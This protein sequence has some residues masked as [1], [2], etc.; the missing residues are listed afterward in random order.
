M[1][2]SDLTSGKTMLILSEQAGLAEVLMAFETGSSHLP[3]MSNS[4]K[5]IGFLTEADIRFARD[6]EVAGKWLTGAAPDIE[7]DATVSEA[8]EKMIAE[9][10]SALLLRGINGEVTGMITNQDL[11]RFLIQVLEGEND[12]SIQT[13]SF[14]PLVNE[15][16]REL[17]AAGL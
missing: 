6:G 2:I 1:T 3:V 9:K 7:Q 13:L 12:A 8:A 17:N 4:G 16:M 15:A 10:S 14:S 11:L 5:I